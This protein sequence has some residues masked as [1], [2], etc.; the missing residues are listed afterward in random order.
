MAVDWQLGQPQGGPYDYL[1]SLQQMGQIA[2]QKQQTQQKQYD[3]SRQ[4]TADQQRP[5]ILSQARGGDYAG[6]QNTAFANGDMDAFKVISGLQED[7]RKQVREHAT[8]IGNVA[9][10]LSNFPEGD[11][12][13]VAAF[14]TAAPELAKY[15]FTPDELA[16]ARNNLSDA[17]LTGY[18]SAADQTNKALDRY[19]ESQKPLTV[20]DGAQVFGAAPMGGGPRPLVAE[21][22]K[23]IVPQKPVWDSVRGGWVYPPSAGAPTGSMTTL[24]GQGGQPASGASGNPYDVVLG[25][26]KFGSPP[27]PLSSMTLGDVYD[28]GRN[29]LIPNSK[30]AGIGRDSRGLIGSSASGAYQITGENLRRFGPQVLGPD[31]EQQTFT[32]EVQDQLGEAIYNDAQRSGTPLNKVWASLSPQQA[33]SLQG[34]PWAQVRDTIVRGE[35]GIGGAPAA[36]QAA[37]ANGGFVPVTGARPQNAPA[38]YQYKADGRT[39]E[40]IAGGPADPSTPTSRNVTSTRK[41]EGDNRKEFENEQTVKNFRVLRPQFRTMQDN[42]QAQEAAIRAGKP[43]SAANDIALVF[44]FMKILDPTSVVR[45]GEYATAKNTAGVDARILNAY[46][47]AL[48]GTFLRPE[49]RRNYLRT[50]NI[51]YKQARDAYNQRAEQYRGYARDYGVNPD[52]V[53]RTYTPDATAQ[54]AAPKPGWKITERK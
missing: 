24:G 52:N 25:K 18:I 44:N 9:A 43:P 5:Q 22:Q 51:A 15:G 33:T 1:Q 50:A 27:A 16:Q 46:N 29:V 4:R 47:A 49:Q 20:A 40:P 3:F 26:G 30:K 10:T 45:E 6:A 34:Q 2:A 12:R 38:G 21:N 14:D 13:R 17:G 36:P 35:T 48:D 7:Q 8:I 19:Y 42:V 39:L 54:T 32:P 31:W 11:P 37:S 53:A 23:D 41:T 28:F